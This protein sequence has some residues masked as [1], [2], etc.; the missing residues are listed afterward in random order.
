[1]RIQRSHLT[2]LL[3]RLYDRGDG[4]FTISHPSSEI[5]DLLTIELGEPDDCTIRFRK[6]R[7]EYTSAY[8]EIHRTVP[9]TV[10]NDLPAPDE[11]VKAAMA[12]GIV[13]IEN[14]EEIRTFLDR[15]GDPDLLAGHP[16]V[17]AGFDTNLLPWRIDRILEL[18]KPDEGAGYVNGFVLATGIRDE[19]DWDFKCHETRPFVDAFGDE[20]E[21]Y[22]NQP[23]GSARIGRLGLLAYRNIRDTQ[24]ADEIDCE[25]GDEQIIPAYD[26]YKSNHRSQILLFSNDRTFVERAHSHTLLAQHVDLPADL[27]RKTS[28]TWREVEL[29]MYTLT[30]IFGIVKLPGVTLHGVWRGKDGLDW[31]HER[32][33]IDCRSTTLD[34]QLEADLSI[35]ESFD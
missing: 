23:L 10:A 30:L 18:R 6:R 7:D 16:P 13:P 21:E 24:Q 27:P 20:Y 12:S 9:E 1:M 15:Y 34:P 3:N 11:Y 2:L 5:G 28:A 22:W 31:Q 25:R 32:V 17:F 19:L 8:D 14:I 33:K 29:L 4:R 35:V 26:T